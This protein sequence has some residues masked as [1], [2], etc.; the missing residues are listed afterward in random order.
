ME[1]HGRVWWAEFGGLGAARVG[2]LSGGVA[3]PLFQPPLS[4]SPRA[5]SRLFLPRSTAFYSTAPIRTSQT[6]WKNPRP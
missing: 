6:Q 5:F 4:E 1:R 3:E 2:G